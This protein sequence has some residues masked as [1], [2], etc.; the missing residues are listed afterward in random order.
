MLV[1]NYLFIDDKLEAELFPAN[2]IAEVKLPEL[3]REPET[4]PMLIEIHDE[5]ETQYAPKICE[6]DVYA[7]W[8]QPH[9]RVERK[10]LAVFDEA[11]EGITVEV[12][13]VGRVGGPI[14]I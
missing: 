1:A 14:R 7:N 11:V 8:S 5:L 4:W 9:V 3:A 2:H 10:E 13:A 6:R 12:V